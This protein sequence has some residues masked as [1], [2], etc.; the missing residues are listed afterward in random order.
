MEVKISGLT[1]LAGQMT[2]V[3][4]F[5]QIATSIKT[6]KRSQK[7]LNETTILEICLMQWNQDY[8]PVSGKLLVKPLD[9]QTPESSAAFFSMATC[10]TDIQEEREQAYE[11]L[12]CNTLP[13][14]NIVLELF[15]ATHSAVWR[16]YDALNKKTLPFALQVVTDLLREKN[17]RT[18]NISYV[19]HRISV[20]NLKVFFRKNNLEI[21]LE[22]CPT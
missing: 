10:I 18:L 16:Y 8:S 20:H 1:K 21:V 3:K 6:I 22:Q 11:F 12:I 5:R 2:V 13:N 9:F 4:A 14:V 15:P 7:P 19:A 17:I